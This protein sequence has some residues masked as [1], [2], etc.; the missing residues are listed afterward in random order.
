MSVTTVLLLSIAGAVMADHD[1]TGDFYGYGM[2]CEY[3]ENFPNARVGK[4]SAKN[5]WK[6]D[7]T[8][9]TLV[10]L[11]GSIQYMKLDYGSNCDQQEG[12]PYVTG[13]FAVFDTSMGS[14][15]ASYD[16]SGDMS[17]SVYHPDTTPM[18][19]R[20]KFNM[21]K[22]HSSEMPKGGHVKVLDTEVFKLGLN[23]IGIY[24]VGKSIKA[25]EFEGV[26]TALPQE[27]QLLWEA[28]QRTQMGNFVMVKAVCDS[29]LY[30][31]HLPENFC[32][33]K[34]PEDTLTPQQMKNCPAGS[35]TNGTPG[36]T[37]MGCY[38]DASL[39]YLYG[40][41]LPPLQATA[42]ASS[43]QDGIGKIDKI[44]AELFTEKDG[45]KELR[46]CSKVWNVKFIDQM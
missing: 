34:Y 20:L 9:N 44:R 29:G 2:R 21:L 31:E 16:P 35:V 5:G 1:T 6:K 42:S 40:I 19:M 8:V 45:S 22:E 39:D 25:T 18:F 12:C 28:N 33:V 17:S 23:G 41:A 4:E 27:G 10:P 38:L 37:D 7:Q 13:G 43:L 36:F 32:A 3:P 14:D 46:G 15:I 30:A 11:T 24:N 26:Y